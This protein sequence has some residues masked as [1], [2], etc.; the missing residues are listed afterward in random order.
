MVGYEGKKD[1]NQKQRKGIPKQGINGE[2]GK[3][4]TLLKFWMG[5]RGG[6]GRQFVFPPFPRCGPITGR[7]VLQLYFKLRILAPEFASLRPQWLSFNIN[8]SCYIPFKISATFKPTMAHLAP[9]NIVVKQQLRGSRR[10]GSLL[11]TGGL[12]NTCA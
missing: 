7:S 9:N 6:K 11:T 1:R 4:E 10:G 12:G 3:G 2:E 5:S 8:R